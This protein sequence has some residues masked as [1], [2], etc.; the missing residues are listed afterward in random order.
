MLSLGVLTFSTVLSKSDC[1][2]GGFPSKDSL[3]NWVECFSEQ[4]PILAAFLVLIDVG[5]YASG[6]LHKLPSITRARV[7]HSIAR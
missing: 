4:H 7:V 3:E 5:L 2:F 6:A 1:S